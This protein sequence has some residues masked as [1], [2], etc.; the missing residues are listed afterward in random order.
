MGS[1]GGESGGKK[2]P[3]R[4]RNLPLNFD[5]FDEVEEILIRRNKLV[6]THLGTYCAELSLISIMIG[7]SY[8]LISS[9]LP[10]VFDGHRT[11]GTLPTGDSN[12]QGP[13]GSF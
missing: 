3:D 4:R 11:A 8:C 13:L 6:H 9:R 2:E 5:A 7:Y 10:Y 12:S 1:N